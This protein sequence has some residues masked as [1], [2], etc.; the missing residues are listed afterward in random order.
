MNM[1][2]VS[3]K[4]SIIFSLIIILLSAYSCEKNEYYE[5]YY[6]GLNYENIYYKINPNDWTWNSSK[7]LYE[8]VVDCPKLTADIYENGSVI[9]QI[10]L[11]QQNVDEV[12]RTLTYTQSYYDQYDNVTYTRTISCD[13]NVGTVCFYFQDSDLLSPRPDVVYNFKITL[14]W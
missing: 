7:G 9:G 3:G 14:L 13:W 6:E 8:C 4:I 11:G 1:K 5:E 10:F 12:Q 2:K